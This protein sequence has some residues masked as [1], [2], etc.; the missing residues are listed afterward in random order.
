MLETDF[1]LSRRPTCLMIQFWSLSMG[2]NSGPFSRLDPT[3]VPLPM[4]SSFDP[5][6][7]AFA[8]PAAAFRGAA[9]H[10]L[11]APRRFPRRRMTNIVWRHSSSADHPLKTNNQSRP[12]P[13][14]KGLGLTLEVCSLVKAWSFIQA[15]DLR[16]ESQDMPR[17]EPRV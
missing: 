12:G 16:R 11:S 15:W 5:F 3:L 4:E 6:S 10:R 8:V 17:L 13:S 14:I 7:P 2:S 1:P 9:F